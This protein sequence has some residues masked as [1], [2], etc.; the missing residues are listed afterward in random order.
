[1]SSSTRSKE[2]ETI[3]VCVLTLMIFY[4]RYKFSLLLSIAIILCLIGLFVPTIT[5]F[6]H[7]GWMKLA[8]GMGIVTGTLLLCL[9]YSFMVVPLGWLS[10]MVGKTNM[11]KGANSSTGFFERNHTYARKDLENAW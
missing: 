1:M 4:A 5:H 11:L 10:R 2:L 7:L 9:V 8:K 3:I 6:F